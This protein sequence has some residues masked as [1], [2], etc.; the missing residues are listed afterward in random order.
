MDT[1]RSYGNSRKLLGVTG[2]TAL[3]C[4]PIIELKS[5]IKLTY[6][7]YLNKSMSVE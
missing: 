7:V 3:D 1:I 4:T 2:A 5:G 6:D